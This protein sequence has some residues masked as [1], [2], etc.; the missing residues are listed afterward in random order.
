MT[1]K[2]TLERG[3]LGLLVAVTLLLTASYADAHSTPLNSVAVKACDHK[4]RSQ[5][6]Q[7]EGGH[8]DL[9]VGTCQYMSKDLI[10][11]RNQPIQKITSSKTESEEEH[12]TSHKQG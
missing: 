4:A 9:Y 7:Y 2:T 3:L 6:C 1:F 8:S 11:V 5:A 12:D 10:C